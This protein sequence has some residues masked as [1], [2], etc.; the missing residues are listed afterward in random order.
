MKTLKTLI[1]TLTVLA[2]LGAATAFAQVKAEEIEEL[3]KPL[4]ELRADLAVVAD[5]IT[6]AVRG[7][8]PAAEPTATAEWQPPAYDD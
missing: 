6:M 3:A 8:A 7:A 5:E 2:T 4:I 1:A